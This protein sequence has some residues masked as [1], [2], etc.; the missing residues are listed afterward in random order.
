M[1]IPV[2]HLFSQDED[3]IKIYKDPELDELIQKQ[4]EININREFEEGYRIQVLLANSRSEVTDLKKQFYR[5]FPELRSY[6][7]YEQPYYKL[8]LG[9]FTSRIEAL[10]YLDR[11]IAVYQSA[12]VVKDQINIK[13]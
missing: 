4:I 12:H 3:P 11:I 8:R 1:L 13:D 5:D 6:I 2:F 7:I 9:D 10:T